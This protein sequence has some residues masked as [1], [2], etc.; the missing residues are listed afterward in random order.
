MSER[1]KEFGVAK[2][3][4]AAGVLATLMGCGTTKPEPGFVSLFDGK[5]LN[6]WDQ[7]SLS[8]WRVEGGVLVADSDTVVRIDYKAPQIS[9]T[10]LS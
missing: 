2:M 8:A 5:T 9:T 6:G 1:I 3:L 10:G 4:L 7:G